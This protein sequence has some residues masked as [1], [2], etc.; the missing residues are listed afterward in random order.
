MDDSSQNNRVLVADILSRN[1][2]DD[3]EDDM[4]SESYCLY[5]ILV[6]GPKLVTS[7][8]GDM[9]RAQAQ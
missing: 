6:N 1:D 9:A 7:P 4:N 2:E 8:K 5:P 3:E